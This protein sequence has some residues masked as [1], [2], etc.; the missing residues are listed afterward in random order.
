[1]ERHEI[2]LNSAENRPIETQFESARWRVVSVVL[3]VLC[4]AGECASPPAVPD[5]SKQCQISKRE[6][7]CALIRNAPLPSLLF[8]VTV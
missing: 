6:K 8:F 1:M 3:P 5:A 2:K 7:L 4:M